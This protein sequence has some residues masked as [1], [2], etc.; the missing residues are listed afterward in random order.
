M[1]EERHCLPKKDIQAYRLLELV[2]VCGEFPAELIY[3][4]AGGPS[5][6][7]NIT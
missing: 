5:Y 7:E 2:A 3:R 1:R 4:L 6:K